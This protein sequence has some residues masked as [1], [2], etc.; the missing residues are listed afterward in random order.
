MTFGAASSRKVS[1]GSSFAI[2]VKLLYPQPFVF[3]GR[4]YYILVKYY[5]LLSFNLKVILCV[6]GTGLVFLEF[7]TSIASLH[8]YLYIW[9][10]DEKLISKVQKKLK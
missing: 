7:Q 6:C 1:V 9:C 3:F 5:F 10:R 4:F 2:R 8:L